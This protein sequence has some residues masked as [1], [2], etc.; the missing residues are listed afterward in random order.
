MHRFFV[1]SQSIHGQQVTLPAEAAR[2]VR[3][4]LR[5]HAGDEIEVLD[6]EGLAYRVE[7]RHTGKKSASGRILETRAAGG[8]PAGPIVLCLAL[9]RGDR[10]EWVLQK[11]TELGVTR[12]QPILTRRTVRGA[13]GD[14]KWQRWQRIVREA[15]EQSGRGRLPALSEPLDFAQAVTACQGLTLFPALA[16]TRPL[17][18]AL[19][20]PQW[21]LTLFAGPEGGFT[22]EEVE[23]ARAA[24]IEPVGL[25]PRILRTETAAI[26][27]LALATAA[28]GELDRPTPRVAPM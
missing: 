16:A 18:A 4:V 11:G 14:S 20:Q 6:G 22:P 17:A 7:L 8:E 23:A 15:A 24:G 25:G 13:P 2:Q 26:T 3:T 28:L 21:P 1:P 5:L 10:F 19:A 12:F 27:L 9:I